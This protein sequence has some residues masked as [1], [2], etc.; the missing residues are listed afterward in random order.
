MTKAVTL[1]FDNPLI[2]EVLDPDSFEVLR[3]GG[4]E[5]QMAYLIR[6]LLKTDLYQVVIITDKPFYYPGVE[7][8][9]HP[10]LIQRG[11]PVVSRWINAYRKKKVFRACTKRRIFLPWYMN[12]SVALI[13]E[14]IRMGVST[15]FRV[16]GDA[17]VDGSDILPAAHLELVYAYFPRF[18]KVICQSEYQQRLLVERWGIDAPVIVMGTDSIAPSLAKNSLLWVG[19]CIELKQPKLFLHIARVFPD[20]ECRMIMT[21]PHTDTMFYDALVEEAESISNLVIETNVPHCEMPQRY[22]RALAFIST[23]LTEG[24]PNVFAEAGM[25]GTP[26][27]SLNVNPAGVL[28]NGE[29]GMCA[30]GDFLKLCKSLK[31]YLDQTGNEQLIRQEQARVFAQSHWSIEQMVASYRRIFEELMSDE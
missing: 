25:A 2:G 10:T 29:L 27:F 19:R 14:A 7:I 24:A 3:Y 8:R 18:D 20:I 26:V 30:Q 21:T 17:V 11:A 1:F 22:A 15:V 31:A 28:E 13:D 9:P 12:N 23:S 5:V 4:V 16:S 6:E